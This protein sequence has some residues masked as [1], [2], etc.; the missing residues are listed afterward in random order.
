MRVGV[1]MGSFTWWETGRK[2]FKKNRDCKG[3]NKVFNNQ[4]KS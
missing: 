2:D 4:K 3:E 1:D